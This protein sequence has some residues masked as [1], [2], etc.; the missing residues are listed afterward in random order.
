M[1][2]FTHTRRMSLSQAYVEFLNEAEARQALSLH[3]VNECAMCCIHIVG[4]FQM[5][6]GH[7]YIELFPVAYDEMAAIVGLPQQPM[8]YGMVK[9]KHYT[10]MLTKLRHLLSQ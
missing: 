2:N 9:Q 8:G 1:F 7:R 5:F 3:K 6:I 4:Q 10:T